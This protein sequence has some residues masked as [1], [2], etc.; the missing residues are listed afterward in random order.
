MGISEHIILSW[1]RWE[2]NRQLSILPTIRVLFSNSEEATVSLIGS[3]SQ[4][5]LIYRGKLLDLFQALDHKWRTKKY[6][7]DRAE[8]SVSSMNEYIKRLRD[9]FDAKREN[10]GILAR[11][12]DVF[13]CKKVSGAWLYR[14]L[15]NVVYD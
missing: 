10:A 1:F 15:A 6:L 13:Q 14:I 8:I 2:F 7:A 12:T 5:E 9:E 11:G 3:L 4:I